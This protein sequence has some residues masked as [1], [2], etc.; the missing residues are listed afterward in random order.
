M[1]Q[2]TL[3]D[4]LKAEQMGVDWQ[5]RWDR[6]GDQLFGWKWKPEFGNYGSRE[7]G[8]KI[9]TGGWGQGCLTGDLWQGWRTG[10]LW[11]DSRT[12]AQALK[13][14]ATQEPVTGATETQWSTTAEEQGNTVVQEFVTA[15]AQERLRG[16]SSG[17]AEL[18]QR[19]LTDNLTVAADWDSNSSDWMLVGTIEV[20]EFRL[21]INRDGGQGVTQV[22]ARQPTEDQE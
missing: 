10:G 16:W 17:K 5:W 9:L 20:C 18:Q 21:D 2:V 11:K 19:P 1:V 7:D 14:A 4:G 15:A 13:T 3:A 6:S 8:L 12:A 22:L